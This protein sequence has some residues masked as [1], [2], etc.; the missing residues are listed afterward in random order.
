[1]AIG[2]ESKDNFKKT[3]LF[4]LS[5]KNNV[6]YLLVLSPVDSEMVIDEINCECIKSKYSQQRWNKNGNRLK[7]DYTHIRVNDNMW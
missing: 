2:K 1:V 6:L 4:G 3:S 5:G 7:K